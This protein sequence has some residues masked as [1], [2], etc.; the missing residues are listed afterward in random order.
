MKNL[1]A[2]L[3]SVAVIVPNVS[4]AD[5]PEKAKGKPKQHSAQIAVTFSSGQREAVQTYFGEQH[6]KGNCPPGLAKKGNGC[7]PPGQA[8]KSYVIG[9]AL[10][11]GVVMQPLPA[12]LSVRIGMPPVGYAYAIVDGDLVKLVAGSMLVVDAIEGLMR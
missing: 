1:V 9:Q 7:L 8:K 4:L 12:E 10:P 3:L 5:K 11:S 6:G 2:L